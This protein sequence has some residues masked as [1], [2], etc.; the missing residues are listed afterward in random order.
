M[1]HLQAAMLDGCR[2]H[3]LEFHPTSELLEST[4]SEN[5][6][7]PNPYEEIWVERTEERALELPFSKILQIHVPDRLPE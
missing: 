1:V 2:Y 5:L 4:F 6:S 7:R 3:G